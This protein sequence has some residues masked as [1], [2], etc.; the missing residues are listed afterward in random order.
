MP[1]GKNAYKL[2]IKYAPGIIPQSGAVKQGYV[3]DSWLHHGPEHRLTEVGNAAGLFPFNFSFLES[4]SIQFRTKYGTCEKTIIMK[5][6]Y[7]K[8]PLPTKNTD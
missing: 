4:V 7:G 1:T 6:T 3:H 8:G 2:S 5:A